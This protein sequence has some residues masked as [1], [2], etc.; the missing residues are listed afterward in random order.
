[1]SN[2]KWLYEGKPGDELP[3]VGFYNGGDW[4]ETE[5]PH[6]M[7]SGDSDF[8]NFDTPEKLEALRAVLT[9]M[10]ETMTEPAPKPTHVRL[11]VDDLAWFHPITDEPFCNLEWF[12]LDDLRK[13]RTYSSR[14]VGSLLD[15]LIGQGYPTEEVVL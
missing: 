2:R 14:V 9:W 5:G 10:L 1:M 13:T 15:A 8:I 12:R 6:L 7:W 11:V 3:R 4:G